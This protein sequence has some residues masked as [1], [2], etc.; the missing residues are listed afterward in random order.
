[1][2]MIEK[3]IENLKTMFRLLKND[4]LKHKENSLIDKEFYE[5]L[6]KMFYSDDG[7]IIQ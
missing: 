1:M 2:E 3:E 4:Y 5:E 6:K 7:N